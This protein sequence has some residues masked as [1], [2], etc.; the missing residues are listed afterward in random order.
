MEACRELSVERHVAAISTAP[1]KA[2]A[3]HEVIV[4]VADRIEEPSDLLRSV[5]VVAG[6]HDDNVE[7]APACLFKTPPD[8]VADPVNPVERD[9]F[10]PV[11][12]RRRGGAVGR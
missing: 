9:D 1:E 8:G 2:R 5:L 4:G 7:A 10:G 3:D 6:N 11:P 12:P